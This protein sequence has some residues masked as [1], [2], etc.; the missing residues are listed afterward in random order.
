MV[1]KQDIEDDKRRVASTARLRQLERDQSAAAVDPLSAGNELFET[2]EESDEENR[3]KRKSTGKSRKS[4]KQEETLQTIGTRRPIKTIDMILMTEPL[5]G[6][7]LISIE[8]PGAILPPT[9]FCSVCSYLSKYNCVKCG[10]LFCSLP[11]LTVHRDTR[12]IRFS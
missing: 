4:H 7:T 1:R 6:D 8:A 3:G 10:A 2:S 5:V 11:C 9:K 12:C